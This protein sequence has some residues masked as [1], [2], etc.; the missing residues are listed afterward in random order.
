[1]TTFT[2]TR[3]SQYRWMRLNPGQGVILECTR[4]GELAHTA[5]GNPSPRFLVGDAGN[6]WRD[7]HSC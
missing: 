1:M 6:A 3:D 4:C 2:G 7:Q 5:P